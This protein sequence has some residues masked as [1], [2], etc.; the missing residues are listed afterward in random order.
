M[1]VLIN[2]NIFIFLISKEKVQAAQK[3]TQLKEVAHNAV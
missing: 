1:F 2:E 3:R